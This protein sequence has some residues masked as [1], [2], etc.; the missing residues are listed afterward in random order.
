MSNLGPQFTSYRGMVLGRGFEGAPHDDEEILHHLDPKVNR[1][2]GLDSL[3][4]P[5][6]K[7]WTDSE[8]TARRFASNPLA[9]G[10][11]TLP[12]RQRKLASTPG[13]SWGVVLEAHHA[14]SPVEKDPSG[15]P[16]R[17]YR[18]IPYSEHEKEVPVW[19][20]GITSV[21]AHVTEG[22]RGETVR[23]FQLP[24]KHWDPDPAYHER[25]A[26]RWQKERDDWTREL[27]ARKGLK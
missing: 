8:P 26:N 2:S 10:Y 25:A 14:L 27:A 3:H 11:E 13:E 24:E 15:E 19:R 12:A 20:P 7:H 5:Y 6:G 18:N 4:G 21:T 16:R 9:G 22:H 1:R 23:S 17:V